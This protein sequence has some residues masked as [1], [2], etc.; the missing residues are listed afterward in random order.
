MC[1][2]NSHHLLKCIFGNLLVFFVNFC[3]TSQ[4]CFKKA[5]FLFSAYFGYHFFVTIATVKFKIVLYFY[6][7]AFNLINL[8]EEIGEKHVLYFSLIGEGALNARSS[9]NKNTYQQPLKRW[10]GQLIKA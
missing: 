7:L 9:M 6:S 8:Q 1:R 3:Q 2:D 5:N 10:T 4:I